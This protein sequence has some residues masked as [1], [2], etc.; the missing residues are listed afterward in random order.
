MN[1]FPDEKFINMD[2]SLNIQMQL[3]NNKSYIQSVNLIKKIKKADR[4]ESI[5]PCKSLPESK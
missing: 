1:N 2:R 3:G 5:F 4:N